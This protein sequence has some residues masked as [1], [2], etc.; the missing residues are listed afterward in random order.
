M[1]GPTPTPNQILAYMW[2]LDMVG[3]L[4]N[5]ERIFSEDFEEWEAW[6][7]DLADFQAHN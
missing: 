3:M 2:A 1:T 7:K 4:E 5:D 6:Q